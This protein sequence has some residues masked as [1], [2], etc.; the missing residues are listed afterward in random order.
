MRTLTSVYKIQNNILS[1]FLPP[2]L[3][4]HGNVM[5][6]S[7][8]EREMKNPEFKKMFEKGYNKFLLSELLITITEIYISLASF[9]RS[10]ISIL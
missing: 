7:T 1:E 5:S 9:D 2:H 4:Q 10:K 3:T 6:Q 8:F